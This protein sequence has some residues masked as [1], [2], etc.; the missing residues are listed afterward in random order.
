MAN[1]ADNFNRANS[2]PIGVPSDGGSAWVNL[3]GTYEVVS[4]QAYGGGHASPVCYLE[5][6]SSSVDITTKISF[7]AINAGIAFRIIDASNFLF[8]TIN[9]TQLSL[10]KKVD[11]VD[12]QIGATQTIA[13]SALAPLKVTVD[14]A[15]LITCYYNGVSKLSLTASEN[16]TGTKHGLRNAATTNRFDDFSITDISVSVPVILNT[17]KEL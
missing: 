1:R 7:V 8:C 16:S 14:S 10:W 2:N 17:R 5:A 15:N 11:G 6:S 9:S 13:Y 4:N 3:L 12:S